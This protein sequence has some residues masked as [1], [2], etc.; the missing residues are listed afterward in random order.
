MIRPL[1]TDR[2]LSLEAMHTALDL[3]N[4]PYADFHRAYMD[5]SMILSFLDG[6]DFVGVMWFYGKDDDGFVQ[7]YKDN[8]LIFDYEG[9]TYDWRGRYTGS[10]IRIGIYRDRKF[11]IEYPDQSIH[12]DDFIV[13]SDEK[14]LDKLIEKSIKRI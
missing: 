8:E 1:Y 11:G 9:I 2:D 14:T 12:F 4:Y 6:G 13:V 3:T 5:R 10:Y 7:V